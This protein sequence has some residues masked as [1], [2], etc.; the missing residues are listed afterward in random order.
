LHS[1][2]PFTISWLN[3]SSYVV[4][5]GVLFLLLPCILTFTLLYINYR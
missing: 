1:L 3:Y 5:Y 4:V 2:F